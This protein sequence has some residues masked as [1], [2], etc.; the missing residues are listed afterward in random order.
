MSSPI[1]QNP[2]VPLNEAVAI[3][4]LAK[5]RRISFDLMLLD[6]YLGLFL[7]LIDR[8]YRPLPKTETVST[9]TNFPESGV[10][11]ST[12]RDSTSEKKGE[13]PSAKE[14]AKQVYSVIL[15]MLDGANA[16]RPNLRTIS[17]QTDSKPVVLINRIRNN[18]VDLKQKLVSLIVLI[19]KR[20]IWFCSLI[21]TVLKNINPSRK[22]SHQIHQLEVEGKVHTL[23]LG[24][25]PALRFKKPHM[26]YISM[27]EPYERIFIGKGVLGQTLHFPTPDFE[28]VSKETI[29]KAV[30]AVQEKLR[31]GDVYL[32]CKGGDDRSAVVA[33]AFK[34]LDL[35][36]KY[37]DVDALYQAA[38]K[39]VK[40]IRPQI[41]T[42]MRD[43][44]AKDWF[45]RY[46]PY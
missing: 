42:K 13:K 20:L 10:E 16:K 3:S 14:Q 39:S 7:T 46:N 37:Q 12:N 36:D 11:S 21:G 45:N 35:K 28:V 1:C 34:M 22:W 19:C 31:T 40:Q 38:Y 25:M 29:Q 27:I 23:R 41:T 2:V 18:I 44:V 43:Q 6:S 30:K 9:Q 4:S 32:H 17:I 5:K 8:G 26:Q 15:R 33:V 24:G